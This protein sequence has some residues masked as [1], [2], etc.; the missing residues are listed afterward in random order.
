MANFTL[1]FKSRIINAASHSPIRF[2]NKNSDGY[3]L[4][5]TQD[6]F[7][8][9]ATNPASAAAL[10]ANADRIDIEGFVTLEK[11]NVTETI[12]ALGVPYQTNEKRLTFAVNGVTEIYQ[13]TLEIK[14]EALHFNAEFARW[15]AHFQRT[16][17]Y[18]LVVKPG[19]TAANIAERLEQV[20]KEEGFQDRPYVIFVSRDGANINIETSD[21]GL[22][23]HVSA[24]GDVIRNGQVSVNT[25]EIRVG[26]QGRNTFEQLRS[27]RIETEATLRPLDYHH[28]DRRGLPVPD[29][30]Y[31]SFT[32][33]KVVEREELHGHAMA[34]G[35][36]K[37][38][39]KYQ[40]FVNEELTQY[41]L[42]LTSWLNANVAKRTMFTATTP[43]LA[44]A[45][46][47]LVQSA[48]SKG[49]APFRTPLI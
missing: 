7:T 41:K 29:A 3:S 4:I 31:T 25:T 36:Q 13:F 18:P 19:D 42:A 9:D 20:L 43:E 34:D 30:K 10:L 21:P 16:F 1:G 37:G 5:G 24:V 22:L 6:D 27:Y 8:G 35:I 26:Y 40:L 23:I 45:S 33:G 15:D 12:G 48:T 44:V 17:K 46:P 32:F 39:Y 28:T 14:L 11:D 2:F 47:E 49:T 38:A